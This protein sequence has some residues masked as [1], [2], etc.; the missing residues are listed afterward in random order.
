MW[1][2]DADIKASF[3]EIAHQPF[4]DK[5]KHFPG[6]ELM[7]KSLKAGVLTE[8]VWS[9]S[10]STLQGEVISPLL[11]NIALHGMEKE[12]NVKRSFQG[13]VLQGLELLE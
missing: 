12:L 10:L 6:R 13:F 9:E 4:L 2:V 1:V 5:V 3:D 8:G 7:H 11:C